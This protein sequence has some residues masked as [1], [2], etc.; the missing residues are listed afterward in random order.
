MFAWALYAMCI[1]LCL[2]LAAAAAERALRLRR[3]ATRW[4]W[5]AA[6]VAS[7]AIPALISFVAVEIPRYAGEEPDTVLLRLRD[8]T[9]QSLAPE[10]WI[11]DIPALNA[12]IA[13]SR[14][15]VAWMSGSAA[16]MLLLSGIGAHWFRRKRS[17]A[18]TEVKG[19]SV[20]VA[21]DAGPAVVGFFRPCIVLPRWALTAPEAALDAVLAHERAHVEA[22][23]PQLLLASLA[24]ICAMPWNAPLWWAVVRLRRAIEIDCD[25]RVVRSGHDAVAYGQLLLDINQRRGSMTL[26]AVALTERH[27]FLETRIRQMLVG[28]HHAWRWSAA[29]LGM[30]SLVMIAAAAHVSPPS[31]FAAQRVVAIEDETFDRLAGYYHFGGQMIMRVAR[32]RERR[33]VHLAGQK[34]WPIVARSKRHWVSS[35][36]AGDYEFTSDALV[37]RQNGNTYRARRV[38][39]ALGQELERAFAA[40]IVEQAP[41]HGT[42]EAVRRVVTQIQ[43]DTLDESQLMPGLAQSLRKNLAGRRAELRS[44]GALQ[45]IAFS[46]VTAGGSD[47]YKVQYERGTD[48]VTIRLAPDGRVSRLSFDEWRS[49]PQQDALA[50]RFQQQRPGA[51]SEDALRRFIDAVRTGQPNYDDLS[52]GMA[53]VVRQQVASLQLGVESFGPLHSI[54][55]DRV[56][57]NGWDVFSVR[58]ENAVIACSI[59]LR[60]DG[61]VTGLVWDM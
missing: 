58:F 46:G 5:L 56:A 40:R 18:R 3:R 35:A 15:K 45:A 51:G 14:F 33:F 52:P 57:P 41:T 59:E 8:T 30:L 21:D 61:K 13:G 37:F 50:E 22:R 44:Y 11:A 43:A 1:S 31:F 2:G 29:G 60:Q 20:Y 48:E 55:F 12:P 28:R 38:S 54:T 53:A 17:W 25:A 27:S 7:I 10:R 34:E 4:V 19:A 16:V 36:P 9:A 23:D 6:L 26:A 49:S 39:A 24:F 32:T 47:T 42:Q